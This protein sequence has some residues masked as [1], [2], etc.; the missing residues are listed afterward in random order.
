MKFEHRPQSELFHWWLI[1][2][3]LIVFFV[4]LGFDSG[5]YAHVVRNDPSRLSIVISVLSLFATIHCGVLAFRLSRETDGLTAFIRH[6]NADPKAVQW[7]LNASPAPH[8][9]TS[10]YLRALV[11][12][13][14]T[15]ADGQDGDHTQL[16]E[17]LSEQLRGQ[18]ETG[19]FVT[20]MLVKLGLL[21]TV[22]GFIL[23]LSSV[24]SI[25][26][27][28]I[29]EA[30]GLLGTMTVGMGV[31]LNTTMLGLISSML[32]GLQYL[33]VDRGADRLIAEA[34][35][36]AESRLVPLFRG[37]EHGV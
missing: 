4:Y 28:D 29:S 24:M 15:L 8:S 33:M 18:H 21:G 22:I 32:L 26:S 5:I 11:V 17:V 3:S 25:E 30:Q 1:L 9:H 36:V 10:S 23:M 7:A 2:A 19:W 12:R 37:T 31:A 16:T 34:V 13:L 14:R 20:N 6:L 35:L 27:F